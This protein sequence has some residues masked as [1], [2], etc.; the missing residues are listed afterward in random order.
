M[1]KR[2][3]F[4]DSRKNSSLSIEINLS[5]TTKDPKKLFSLAK[6]KIEHSEFPESIKVIKLHFSKIIKVY[7]KN[8]ELF[9]KK[10]DSSSDISD[11]INVVG[12]RLKPSSI[13]FFKNRDQIMR[14][15]KSLICIL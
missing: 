7:E 10:N 13:I 3:I 8:K 11:F 1:Y 9:F 12:S 14:Q 6:E 15:N 2:Q 5:G 4:N